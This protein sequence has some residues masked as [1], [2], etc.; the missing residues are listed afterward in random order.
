MTPR[1][2]CAAAS[3]CSAASRYHRT[4]S[5][6]SRGTPR[7]FLYMTPRLYCAAR[8]PWSA[9]RRYHRT[10]SVSSRGDAAAVLIHGPDVV[11]R[12]GVPLLGGEPNG[13]DRVLVLCLI[14]IWV[15]F[16]AFRTRI[17]RPTNAKAD[18]QP[19]G[20]CQRCGPPGRL[21]YHGEAYVFGDE[22]GEKVTS[23]KTAW[24]GTCRRAGIEDLQVRDLRREFGS[25]LR[26]SGASDHDV[27]D[28]LGHANITTT[29]RYLAST[30]LRLEK[31]LANLESGNGRTP[32][33]QTVDLTG[34]ENDSPDASHVAKSFKL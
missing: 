13:L 23:V 31:A 22:V 24:R 17:R 10:A 21:A 32:V 30:P 20:E 34:Q 19:A 6:S 2:N 15:P 16:G 29:S 5:V 27:R 12:Q 26:E 18:E 11:L 25:R 28:F 4:A 8:C 7:P 33:A 14:L 3:P 9:A 1:L